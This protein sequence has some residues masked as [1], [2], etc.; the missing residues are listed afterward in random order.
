MP[1][2]L[3]AKHVEHWYVAALVCESETWATTKSQERRTGV[4]ETMI[5]FDV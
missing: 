4:N 2:K 3:N 5:L 1:V